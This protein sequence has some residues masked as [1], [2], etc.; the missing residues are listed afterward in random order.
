MPLLPTP[1]N[2]KKTGSENTTKRFQTNPQG[3]FIIWNYDERITADETE[4]PHAI[5]E[6]IVCT[7][8]LVSMKTSK[9]KAKPAGQFEVRLAPTEN[10]VGR[11][12]PGSWCALLMSATQIP[13]L[14]K[15]NPGSAN[16]KTL[17]MFGKIMSV[18]A[19]ATVDQLTGAVRTEYIVTG[20]DWGS[21][22][23]T[24]LYIDSIFNNNNFDKLSAIGHQERILFE[25]LTLEYF[26]NKNQL[27][28]A[29]ALMKNLIKLWGAPLDLLNDELIGIASSASNKPKD[30]VTFTSD[31]QYQLPA[32]VATYLFSGDDSLGLSSVG[33]GSVLAPSVN[34]ANLIKIKEGRLKA[35]DTYS[36]DTE[37][38]IGF[39]NPSA[40]TGMHNFWQLLTENC[41]PTVNELVA[42]LRWEKNELQLA[43]YRRSRP[44]LT[45]KEFE[46]SEEDQVVKNASLF[47]NVRTVRIPQSRVLTI[48]A[49]TDLN[50]KINFVEIKPNI[51]DI[52]EGF[53]SEIK[54][55]SQFV[56]RKAY[57]RDGFKPFISR[58]TFVP[59]N[60]DGDPSP[61]EA[62]QWKYLLKEWHFGKDTMLN[63][64][65]SFMGGDLYVGVGDNIMIDASTLGPAFNVGQLGGKAYLLAHVEGIQHN[66]E[67]IDE[68][69]ARSFITTISFVRGIIVDK[70]RNIINFPKP[71]A[72]SAIPFSNVFSS[73][74]FSTDD[75]STALDKNMSEIEDDD[76]AHIN[77]NEKSIDGDPTLIKQSSTP[78]SDFLGGDDEDDDDD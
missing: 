57:A 45:R 65:V 51:S 76:F 12:T 61:L 19:N 15:D 28:T 13:T 40:L 69:G 5:H 64:A 23:E 70:N 44:F 56:D 53:Q 50:E 38:A 74:V 78:I 72:A 48:N 31:A 33:L 49:G 1:G 4:D 17:K 30:E 21:I 6:T 10:W 11:I 9:Q 7:S 63:G 34:F 58:P 47:K 59:T 35:Y 55:D 29:G 20:K 14:K 37:D 52:P 25:K 62:T 24:T 77:T 42:D 36:G 68:T 18:R 73:S 16:K 8:N 54:I 2:K 41:N 75:K 43:L 67:V 27:P 66:F 3:A 32:E 22:F 26:D 71:G 60:F 39:L 46:G